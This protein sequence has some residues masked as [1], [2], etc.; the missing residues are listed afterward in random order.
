MVAN[1]LRNSIEIRVEAKDEI[2][3]KTYVEVF[4]GEIVECDYLGDTRILKSVK[5]NQI[6]ELNN[7]IKNGESQKFE[8]VFIGEEG[9]PI[10][11]KYYIEKGL[12]KLKNQ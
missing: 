10:G 2:E 6:L 5:V 1:L 3:N 4:F 7:Y 9:I 8:R 12:Y 11:L